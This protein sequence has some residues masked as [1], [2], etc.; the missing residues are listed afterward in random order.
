VGEA[1]SVAAPDG[2]SAMG[3]VERSAGRSSSCVFILPHQNSSAARHTRLNSGWRSRRS[4][5]QVVWHR[6]G[7]TLAVPAPARRRP[8]IASTP[9]VAGH[10]GCGERWYG[11]GHG[12]I[13]ET[14]D[15]HA[16]DRYSAARQAARAICVHDRCGRSRTS[17]SGAACRS[18]RKSPSRSGPMPAA[19]WR[20]KPSRR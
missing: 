12:G 19:G 13:A 14:D 8:P 7:N 18:V 6:R 20:L 5:N 2:G 16:R 15:R 11:Y 3:R 10:R 9:A 17:G 4:A 1:C